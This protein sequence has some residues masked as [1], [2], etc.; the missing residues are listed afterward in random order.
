MAQI[1][2]IVL[3]LVVTAVLSEYADGQVPRF[4]P[5]DPLRAMPAPMPVKA[6][7]RENINDI[8]DLLW[9]S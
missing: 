4:F 5:D 7:V 8:R 6:A 2:Q 3:T 9:T 1:R